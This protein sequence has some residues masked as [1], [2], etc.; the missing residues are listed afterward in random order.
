MP[1]IALLEPRVLLGVVEQNPPPDGMLGHSMV[2]RRPYP[3][4]VWEYDIITRR[5]NVAR[6]N[7]P[8]SPAIIVNQQ[9]VGKMQGGFV[10]TREKKV[11]EPTT[12]RWLREPG[13]LATPN[14]EAAVLR[15]LSEL[16]ARID[17]WEEFLIWKMLAVGS[18]NLTALGHAVSIDYQIPADHKPTVATFWNT[19][20]ADIITDLQDFKRI[21]SRST[22]A[23]LTTLIGN[24]VTISTF[25][26]QQQVQ[27]TLSDSQKNAFALEGKIPRFQQVDFQEYDRGYMDD[28]T[29]PANPVFVPYVPD[30]YYAGIAEGGPGDNY[31][32]L[33]GPAADDEAPTGYIGRFA[34]TW[35]DH[36]PSSRQ[37]LVESNGFPV[38]YQPN[39]MLIPRVF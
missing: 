34:K 12:I 15:E 9:G 17:R 30:G 31:A 7:T 5:R 28:F 1:D 21:I 37:I 22:D 39:R 36:D 3:L 26:R 8:N 16:M 2:P 38:L 13:Q 14:A 10:Y 35:K 32:Y 33:D 23:T 29:D 4:P 20:L 27:A 6:P 11:F 18:F 25:W 19:P 24:S